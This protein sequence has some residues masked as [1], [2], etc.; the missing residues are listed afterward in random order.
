MTTRKLKR[1][2]LTVAI[3]ALMAGCVNMATP[4]S[5]ITATYTSGVKYEFLDCARLSIEAR[6]LAR[7]ENQLV[8]AQE[9]RVKHSDIQAYWFRFGQGDGIEAIHLAHVRGEKEAV[10]QAMEVK[11]C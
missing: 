9:E 3:S 11:R 10:R 7:R 1:V 6:Y 8:A 2:A 4:P 5:Q